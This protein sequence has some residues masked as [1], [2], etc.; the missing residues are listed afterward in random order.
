MTGATAKLALLLCFA[1]FVQVMPAW[2]QAA[3]ERFIPLQLII[4]DRW[5][6][7]RVI[8]YPSGRF[9]EGLRRGSPSV[10]VGPKRWVHPK[11]QREL[12]V[13]FRSRDGQNA[14][15]QIFAVRDDQTAIG[16]VADSRF[17]ITACDQEGKYPLGLW[18]QG[19]IR[20]YEYQCW[21]GN[22]ARPK[23][24]TI[25]IKEIDYECYGLQHCFRIEWILRDTAAGR[26]VDHRIYVFA[27]NQGMI[28]EVKTD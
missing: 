13:Y 9:V 14:A 20:T 28:S 1:S 6:G 17:G 11:T 18:R 5:N 12:T 22:A 16:R 7:E 2:A 27:P 3:A 26:A 19:E 25:A 10:W 15:D 4:G 21:Y 24:S 8:T 23:I